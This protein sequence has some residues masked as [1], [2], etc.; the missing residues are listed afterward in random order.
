MNAFAVIPWTWSASRVV[1]IVTPVANIPSVRRS[2]IRGSSP[3]SAGSSTACGAGTSSKLESPI[4]SGPAHTAFPLSGRSNSFGGLS[5]L[6]GTIGQI[7][8]CREATGPARAVRKVRRVAASET[9]VKAGRRRVRISNPGKQLFPADGI[10]KLD[11]AEYYVAVE[12]AMRP[13]VAT[14]RST[15]GAGTRGSTSPSSSSRRSPRACR[16][17]SGASRSRAGARAAPS[18][19]PSAARRSIVALAQF[20]CVTPHV[21]TARADATDRPDRLVFDLDPPDADERSH[22]PA[23]RA[24]ALELGELLRELGLVPFAMTSGSRGIHVVAPLRRRAH[25]DEARATAGTI[26]E[27]VAERRPDELTTAWR[28]EKRG[29][30]VLVDVARN[31]YAQTTVAPYAVRAIPGA[32]VATPLAWDE[33]EDDDLHP[34]RWTLANVPGRLEERGCPWRGLGDA[35]RALPRL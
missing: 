17:G 16:T 5:G 27:R 4:P 7:V 13:H 2:A 18:P 20:N 30:R 6:P 1:M 22:F 15:S 34:R 9:T 31:T 26:A 23:I 8:T 33:L 10:T 19:T 3:S 25:A 11:L 28:K 12:P 35:A 21:W 24:G 29:G 32:P 14:A